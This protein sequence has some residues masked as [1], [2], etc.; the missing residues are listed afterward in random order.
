MILV[1]AV[2]TTHDTGHQQPPIS[3]APALAHTIW[4]MV[5]ISQPTNVYPMTSP[6]HADMHT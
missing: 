3:R 2:R 5:D 4:T 1:A 6:R